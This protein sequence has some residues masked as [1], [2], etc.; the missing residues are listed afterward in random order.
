MPYT[1]TQVYFV[2]TQYGDAFT[3]TGFY[4]W[5][6]KRARKAGVPEKRSP[7]GLRKACCRRLA[8]AGCSPHEIMSISGHVTLREVER[9]TKAANR[10]RLADSAIA[11]L[12][13]AQEDTVTLAKRVSGLANSPGYVSQ[14]S[15]QA[16]DN[17]VKNKGDGGSDG[18]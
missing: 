4:N 14:F 2:Q 8:E 18:L 11:T 7:H 15:P 3:D 16:L 12:Q 6:T 10:A 1:E 13:S 17:A 5:F 9:Y